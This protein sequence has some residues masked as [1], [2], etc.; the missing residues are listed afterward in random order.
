V[1]AA[2]GLM[3]EKKPFSPPPATHAK[4]YPAHE[5]HDDEKVSIAIDPFDTPEK[6]AIF[7]TKFRDYGFLP[8]RII[9]S[10]D[11]DQTLILH[12]LSIE[13]ITANRHRLEPGSNDE[14]Y[15]RLAHVEG[16]N[17]KGPAL[18][19]P[20][21]KRPKPA[22]KNETLNEIEDAQFV[23]FPVEAHNQ[24]S[25]FLFFDISGIDTPEAGAHIYISGIKA[26]GKELFYFDIPLEKYLSSRPAK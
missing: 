18:P 19:I 10:N 16:P 11:G 14:L 2:L 4:T 26:G 8:V 1:A 25:G 21:P 24:R 3:A 9:V 20:L 23:P 12:D 7:H 22:V 5:A 6:A 17:R 15:R 13:Y